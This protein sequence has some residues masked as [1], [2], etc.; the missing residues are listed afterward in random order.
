M[1]RKTIEF[2]APTSGVKSYIFEWIPGEDEDYVQ[3]PLL[4]SVQM[5]SFTGTPEIGSSSMGSCIVE[6]NKRQLEVWVAR[7]VHGETVVEGREAVGDFLNK[8]IPS[9]DRESI[10]QRIAYIETRAKKKSEAS[11]SDEP[12]ASAE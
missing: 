8:S 12:T 3:E 10:R 7:V 11:N 4:A 9:S 5:K 2:T 1:E 6:S